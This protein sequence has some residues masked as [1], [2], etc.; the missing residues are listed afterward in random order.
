MPYEEIPVPYEPGNLPYVTPTGTSQA[1]TGF[2]NPP[3][4]SEPASVTRMRILITR[5]LAEAPAMLENMPGFIQDDAKQKPAITCQVVLKS[6]FQA[7]GALSTTPEGTLRMASPAKSTQ[8]GPPDMLVENFFDY[9]DVE[10]II[11]P[12][13]VEVA[14]RIVGRG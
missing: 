7:Q 9:A 14:S 10:A 11:L 6:G 12:R 1:W 5:L 13:K 2:T 4:S 8:H 3:A